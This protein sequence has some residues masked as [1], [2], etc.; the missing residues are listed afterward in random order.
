MRSIDAA[1]AVSQKWAHSI[2]FDA[3]SLHTYIQAVASCLD[4]AR[5]SFSRRAGC[6]SGP[7]QSHI[8]RYVLVMANS[9]K[10]MNLKEEIF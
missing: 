5:N 9:K 6:W 7:E 3:A 10:N 4:Q 1:L 8:E 2:I